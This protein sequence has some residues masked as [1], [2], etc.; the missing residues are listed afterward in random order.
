MATH[1]RITRLFLD[2]M[3]M[4]IGISGAVHLACPNLLHMDLNLDY[5]Q[6]GDACIICDVCLPLQDLPITNV[7]AEAMNQGVLLAVIAVSLAVSD[8]TNV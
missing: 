1:G 5:G 2:G 8:T 6:A 3:P 7:G 4:T